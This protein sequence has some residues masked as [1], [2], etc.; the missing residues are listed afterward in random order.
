VLVL[1]RFAERRPWSRPLAGARP[2]VL[3]S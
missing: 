1:V 2:G 3:R